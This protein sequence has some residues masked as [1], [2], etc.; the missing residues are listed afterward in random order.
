MT[1]ISKEELFKIISE[2]IDEMKPVDMS[3]A[4]N[5]GRLSKDSADDQI[6][7]YILKFENESITSDIDQEISESLKKLSL[8]SILREQEE[9]VEA[10]EE[11]EEESPGEEATDAEPGEPAGSE[12][13][14]AEEAAP[15]IQKLPLDVDAFAKK[16]ARLS[17]HAVTILDIPTVVVNRALNFLKENYDQ[18]HVLKMI[19]ILNTDF[20][21]NLGK[22][23]ESPVRPPALGAFGGGDGL[24]E[25]GGG[26]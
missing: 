23:K 19:D 11:F 2:Q 14:S 18:E 21:F 20:D 24:P 7:S 15:D 1:K 3:N 17:M 13:M 10:E 22:E 26:E 16:V 6:D 12:D 5:A 9:D 4:T 25:T 8:L